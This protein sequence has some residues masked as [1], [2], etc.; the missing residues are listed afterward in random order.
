MDRKAVIR[1]Y[2]ERP[3]SRGVFA[4][5]SKASG[6]VWV[7]SYPNLTAAKNGLWFDSATATIV[8]KSCRPNGSNTARTSSNSRFSKNSI[9][10]S[11]RWPSKTS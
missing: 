7:D 11:P 2:K 10:T 1:E 8:T 3:V 9:R 6:T 4:V 5:L